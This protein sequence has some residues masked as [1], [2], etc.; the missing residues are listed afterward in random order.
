MTPMYT[1]RSRKGIL[2]IAPPFLHRR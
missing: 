2:N 1:I